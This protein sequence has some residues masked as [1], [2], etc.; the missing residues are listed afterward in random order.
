[1]RLLVLYQ[2]RDAAFDHPGYYEGFERLVAE[3]ILSIHAGLSY[4]GIS[5]HRGWGAFWEEAAEAARRMEAD[6]VFLQFFHGR[7][8]DPS[9]GILR[10]R[11]LPARPTIF[12]SLG[13]GY[14]GRWT[15]P[16]P[17]S[18]RIASRLAD[19]SFQTGMGELSGQM[20]RGGSRNLVLM[21][22]GCCQ[23]RFASSFEGENLQPEFDV[24]FIGNRTHSR[25]PFGH[26]RSVERIRIGF[27][28]TFTR[29]Y[30]RRFGL[31]GKGWDG[32]G[33][34]QGAI[35]FAQQNEACRRSAVV[36]GGTPGAFHDYYLSDRP[37]IA[38]ASGTPL[39]D[40]WIRGV[41]RI[42]EPERDWWLAPDIEG[43][44]RACDRLIGM[45]PSERILLGRQARENILARHTQYH[46]CREMV[47][48]VHSVRCARNTGKR[49]AVPRLSFLSRGGTAGD[50]Q[51][52]AV[53][54]WEG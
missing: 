14:G 39:V 22:H 28:R 25:N 9:A 38:A 37:F 50:D 23:V 30:G 43:M 11:D 13:D 12:T 26:S 48:I 33:S 44:V 2:A 54:G 19:L 51:V 3:G 8:P 40:Y 41:D 42:L 20:Y 16:V 5:E 27:V 29:R 34:W 15:K 36:A 21:P 24:V 45:S 31:F 47:E 7:I 18:Y 46:R 35:P 53:V 10:L 1:M 6:A 4:V 52:A 32:N 17:S 49:A